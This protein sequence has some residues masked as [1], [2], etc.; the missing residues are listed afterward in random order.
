MTESWTGRH[1]PMALLSHSPAR[2]AWRF[3]ALAGGM[4][5]EALILASLFGWMQPLHDRAVPVPVE[6]AYLPPPEPTAEPPPDKVASEPVPASASTAPFEPIPDAAPEPAT[7]VPPVITSVA[8]RPADPPSR[9]VAHRPPMSRPAA[10]A[11]GTQPA[12]PAASGPVSAESAAPMSAAAS[13]A[14]A[15]AERLVEDTLR[16][17]I[18]EAVQAASRCPAAARM[19][20][21]AGRAGI[22]FDYRDGAIVGGIQVTHSTGMPVL[23]GAALAA[24]REAHYPKATPE[25]GARVLRLLIWVEEAC[26]G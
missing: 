19:M 15:A 24:V 10:R 11:P 5:S 18:R 7:S 1:H 8:P 22:A 16:G 4:V 17:R 14:A 21:L 13:A 26:A 2:M 9:P 12:V 20:G 25:V 3:G 6:L 23:D